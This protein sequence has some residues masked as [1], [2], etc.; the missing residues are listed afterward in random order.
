MKEQVLEM[1]TYALN[2]SARNQG[3]ARPGKS[4]GDS[5]REFSK[6]SSDEVLA[7]SLI[8]QSRRKRV[9]D[10][11]DFN[12][13]VEIARTARHLKDPMH[14]R[15]DTSEIG[16]NKSLSQPLYGFTLVELLVVIAIIAILASLLL[17]ALGKSKMKGEALTC[18]NNIRQ[19][20]LSLTMHDDEAKYGVSQ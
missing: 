15:R 6:V 18:A 11:L 14:G 1:A 19:L 7:A 3:A 16:K 9:F 13:S 8:Q 20:S 2:H 12:A 10:Q 17:P 4:A 5:R